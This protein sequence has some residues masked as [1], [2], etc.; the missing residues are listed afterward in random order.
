M[1]RQA[2]PRRT[3]VGECAVSLCEKL[4]WYYCADCEEDPD[5][6]EVGFYWDECMDEEPSCPVCGGTDVNQ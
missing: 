2:V 6:D 1:Y 4:E 3:D 5:Q